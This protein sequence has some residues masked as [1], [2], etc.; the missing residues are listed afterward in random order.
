[1]R[2]SGDESPHSK[3]VEVVTI[4]LLAVVTGWIMGSGLVADRALFGL[5]TVC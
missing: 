2:E 3:G 4:D 5:E 1:M